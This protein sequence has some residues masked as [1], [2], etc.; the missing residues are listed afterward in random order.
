MDSNTIAKELGSR[1]KMNKQE[2][3]EKINQLIENGVEYSEDIVEELDISTLT[4]IRFCE[5]EKIKL[6]PFKKSRYSYFN[7]KRDKKKD[8][9]IKRG[10]TLEMIAEKTGVTRERVRQYIEGT[11][12]Y[13]DWQKSRKY[14]GTKHS[15][16]IK[17][18][19]MLGIL[20]SQIE[21][22]ARSLSS[23]IEEIARRKVP[24]EDKLA[25]EKTEE[26]FRVRKRRAYSFDEI[27]Y[28]FKDYFDAQR[29]NEKK[30][31][32]KF[33]DKYGYWV[34]NVSSFLKEVELSTLVRPNNKKRMKTPKYKKQA[35]ERSIP[36]EITRKDIGY[37][38]K[39]HSY[40][41]YQFYYKGNKKR[42]KFSN[43]IFGSGPSKSILNYR[44]ASQIYEALDLGFTKE[45]TL[46]LLDKN[47]RVYDYATEHKKE[48]SSHIVNCLKQIFPDKKISKPY[49]N[50]DISF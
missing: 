28:F 38:L 4:L 15:R 47:E 1:M 10:L 46:E 27:F 48:I 26:F 44:T 39:L 19:E 14:F 31:V 33:A 30:S 40:I 29:K 12:L 43:R 41:A 45:E 42:P 32:E 49:L 50:F 18:K 36:V 11:C 8:R 21:Q 22:P 25:Y 5:K 7:P 13:E 9:L 2:R 34:A 20:A 17:R 16:E 37:F 3:K 35:L 23:Q 24:E 6:L